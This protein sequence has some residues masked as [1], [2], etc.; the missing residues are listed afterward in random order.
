MREPVSVQNITREDVKRVFSVAQMEEK[1]LDILFQIC[2]TN[3]GLRGAV[4]VF[5]NTAAVFDQDVSSGNLSRMMKEMNIG[6]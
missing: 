5:V 4:N 2:R 6:R 1:S 3:W